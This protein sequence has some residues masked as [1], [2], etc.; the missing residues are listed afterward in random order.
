MLLKIIIKTRDVRKEVEYLKA[1][2]IKVL[3]GVSI[4]PYY[5]VK[6]LKD[7]YTKK[8][9]YYIIKLEMSSL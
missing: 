1:N 8:I 9:V 2:K 5:L 4:N 7:F 6:S 3:V